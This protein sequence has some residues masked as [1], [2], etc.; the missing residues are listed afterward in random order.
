MKATINISTGNATNKLIQLLVVIFAISSISYS[1]IPVIFDDEFTSI[2]LDT[3]LVYFEDKTNELS[4]NDFL[5]DSSFNFQCLGSY[6]NFGFTRST[7]WVR[8]HVQNIKTKPFSPAL[9]LRANNTEIS[10]IDLYQVSADGQLLDSSFSGTMLPIATRSSQVENITFLVNIPHDRIRT[11]YIRVN[12]ETPV[13]IDFSLM[14]M[15]EFLKI[16]P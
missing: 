8:F 12:S 10:Y 9:I 13:I 4:I 1:Q 5:T 3:S 11:F 2:S 6:K 16:D 7:F 15:D 14:V